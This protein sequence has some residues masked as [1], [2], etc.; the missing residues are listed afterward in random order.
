MLQGVPSS[1]H[2]AA[3]SWGSSSLGSL[4]HNPCKRL[5][6]SWLPRRQILP[7]ETLS[8]IQVYLPRW[9]PAN[10]FLTSLAVEHEPKWK[11]L[12]CM[13]LLKKSI[14]FFWSICSWNVIV[15]QLSHA[16]LTETQ[17]CS[18]FSWCRKNSVTV[19]KDV[20]YCVWMLSTLY[21]CWLF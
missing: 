6:L 2:M 1:F 7:S 18:R 15:V 4:L 13:H 11:C 5:S 3:S 10:L 19:R 16:G 21:S 20:I 9:K 8:S 14:L 12:K 17:G